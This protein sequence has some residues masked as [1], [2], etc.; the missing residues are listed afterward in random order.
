M[1]T[2]NNLLFFFMRY[3]PMKSDWTCLISAVPVILLVENVFE[4]VIFACF[5]DIDIVCNVSVRLSVS[6][7]KNYAILKV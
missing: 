7:V 1:N 2:H 6:P 4:L 3:T 5:T